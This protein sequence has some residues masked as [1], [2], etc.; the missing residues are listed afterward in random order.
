MRIPGAVRFFTA[1]RASHAVYGSIVVLAVVTGLDEA[2]ASAREAFVGTIGA[3]IAVALSEIYADMIA[4]TIRD[5]R[6]PS[7]GEWHEFVIDMCFGF[8]AACF[9]AFFF[10]LAWSGAIGLTNAFTVAEW[11]GIVVL[12]VYVL[13]AARAAGLGTVRALLWAGGLTACGIGLVE[14]KKLAGH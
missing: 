4:A 2:S 14:L 3:A 10:V 11:S 6:P 9:P 8:G 12:W 7:R 1:A 13:V 5:R